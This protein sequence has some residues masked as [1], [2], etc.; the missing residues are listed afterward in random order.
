M[1]RCLVGHNL[2]FTGR[3]ANKK[4]KQSIRVRTASGAAGVTMESYARQHQLILPSRTKRS[5][6]PGAAMPPAAKKQEQR[7]AAAGAASLLRQAAAGTEEAAV[8]GGQVGGQAAAAAA[9]AAHGAATARAPKALVS[10]DEAAPGRLLVGEVAAAAATPGRNS[11]CSSQQPADEG[12]QAFGQEH[13][14]RAAPAVAAAATQAQ[15]QPQHQSVSDSMV[16]PNWQ[17]R[18]NNNR[19]A[20]QAQPAPAVEPGAAGHRH[21]RRC[22][23]HNRPVRGGAGGGVV[24][25]FRRQ[26]HMSDDPEDDDA[27]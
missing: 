17:F 23:L 9:A 5:S 8:A 15:L 4:W 21:H 20:A 26:L 25:S 14:D 18:L 3:G 22:N 12:P 19:I 24:A 13:T 16:P 27:G 10:A 11:V 2:S 7:K 1:A 6:T